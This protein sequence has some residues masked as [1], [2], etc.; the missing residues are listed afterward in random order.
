[1]DPIGGGRRGASRAD[2]GV[3]A[4]DGGEE[5]VEVSVRE[6]AAGE[7]RLQQRVV[8]PGERRHRS[9]ILRIPLAR[10][11]VRGSLGRGEEEP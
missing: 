11:L 5:G 3:L 1:M 9:S 10:A 8:P 6:R 2:T 4:A 7:E